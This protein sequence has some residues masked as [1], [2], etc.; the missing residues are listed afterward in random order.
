MKSKIHR[1]VFLLSMAITILVAL[2]ISLVFYRFETRSKMDS[3]KEKGQLLS[4]LITSEGI[5]LEEL[6]NR[7][8]LALRITLLSLEGKVLYDNRADASKMENH[9][10]RPEFQAA[11]EKGEGE[12]IRYSYTLGQDTYYYALKLED[13]MVLRVSLERENIFSLFSKIIPAIILVIIIIS[14]LSFY[15][16]SLLAQ[17]ILRPIDLLTKKLQRKIGEEEYEQLIVY[18]ELSPLIRTLESQNRLIKESNREL[19]EKAQLLD[20]IS[21]S[22]GEGIIL[23]DDNK[24]ILSINKSGIRLFN[25]SRDNIYSGKN[26]IHLCRN[27]D[28]NQT[29]DKSIKEKASKELIIQHNNRY[30]DIYIN[31]VISNGFL[32]GLLLLVVDTTEKHKLDLMRREFSANV[33]H[34]L[35]TPLTSING[36][37][38]MIERGMVKGEDIVKFASIIRKE[39]QR[40]LNLIDD[41]IKLSKIEDESADKELEPI[42]LHPIGEEVIN[43]L[44][45]LAD[46]KDIKLEYWGSNIYIMGNRGMITDLIYN[47]VENSIKY[48]NPGGLVQLKIVD[49]SPQAIISV[50]DT[51]VG[52][53]PEHQDRIFERFYTVDES[54]SRGRD[55]TGLGLSI[56]KHIVEYHRGKISLNSQVGEGTEISVS[57]RQW[58]MG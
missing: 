57:F 26:F 27:M 51:G 10:D 58:T 54:R 41:I 8:Q 34:E 46:D 50:K 43:N 17:H 18:E 53:P 56:V 36:Y 45:I 13:N 39:G 12:S 22:M 3:L 33:S 38:E 1:N 48:T 16:S 40:L 37:A 9:R 28:L 5:E 52:I 49:R 35:K 55:S 24:R 14:I 25:G 42:N 6:S 19:E 2:F 31:P 21:S 15:S 29:L 30:L 4:K 44:K 23:L 11:L 47:L 20:V 32:T 7:N